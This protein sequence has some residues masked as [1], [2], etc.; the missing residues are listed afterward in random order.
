MHLR[1]PITRRLQ[2]AT[3]YDVLLSEVEEQLSELNARPSGTLD[4]VAILSTMVTPVVLY[5]AECTPL[6]IEQFQRLN[7]LM[8]SFVLAV[9][10][11]FYGVQKSQNQLQSE[12]LL[13]LS[14]YTIKSI[15]SGV[16]P[17]PPHPPNWKFSSP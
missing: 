6:T 1:H 15:F 10:L 7:A 9:H 4:R 17:P 8:K 2:Q 3:A 16:G 14:S 11:G 5:R 13:F 12:I